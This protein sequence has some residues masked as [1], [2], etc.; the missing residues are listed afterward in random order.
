MNSKLRKLNTT[1]V[2]VLE[3]IE[4]DLGTRANIDKSAY[5]EL[6]ELI[7]S[8]DQLITL[9]LSDIDNRRALN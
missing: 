9:L 3:E 6:S 2:N 4:I 5:L 7:V 1:I 8:I